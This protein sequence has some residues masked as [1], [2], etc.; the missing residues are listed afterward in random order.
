MVATQSKTRADLN[1]ENRVR[2]NS[3]HVKRTTEGRY[4]YDMAVK[5]AEECGFKVIRDEAAWNAQAPVW[6]SWR[7]LR[8]VDRNPIMLNHIMSGN[9]RSNAPSDAEKAAS[10]AKNS[11]SHKDFNL[12]QKHRHEASGI[13]AALRVLDPTGLVETAPLPDGLGGV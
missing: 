5:A 7:T 9:T 11:K 3:R 4:T 10:K 8:I 13:K 12:G 6:P 2:R 1:K